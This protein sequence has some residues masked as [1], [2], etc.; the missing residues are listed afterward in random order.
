MADGRDPGFH[1]QGVTELQQTMNTTWQTR[2]AT[3]T[4]V[5]FHAGTVL[6]AI[7][8]SLY[9]QAYKIAIHSIHI[10]KET[11]TLLGIQFHVF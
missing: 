7:A 8:Q 9:K 6:A 5:G 4:V 3:S 10:V 2:N 11:S 1:G